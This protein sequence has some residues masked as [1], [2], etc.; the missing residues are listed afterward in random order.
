MTALLSDEPQDEELNAA[1]NALSELLTESSFEATATVSDDYLDT[2]IL[3]G[4]TTRQ[5][6]NS[7][8]LAAQALL[9]SRRRRL[10]D[11]GE[12]GS[13]A[14]NSLTIETVNIN[15]SVT[16]GQSLDSGAFSQSVNSR[17][18]I[19]AQVYFS[20]S[21]LDGSTSSSGR[22]LSEG[23]FPP[24]PKK[25]NSSS[26][27]RLSTPYPV[28]MNPLPH[29]YQHPPPPSPS[30]PPPPRRHRRNRHVGVRS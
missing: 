5:A 9:G 15:I 11:G 24:P 12:S 16:A 18:D 3:N 14:A 29:P 25:K 19:Q 20:S 27:R 13:E 8:A 1:S 17:S 26:G 6:V 22:R 21:S 10:Q 2:A 23:I 4:E 28:P 7:I 30:P